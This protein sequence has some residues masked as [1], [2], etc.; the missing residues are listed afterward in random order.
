MKLSEKIASIGTDAF[1]GCSSLSSVVYAG[2]I[3]GWCGISGLG[4]IMTSD[5]ELS[6]GGNTL[7]GK[8]V[9]PEG[10]GKISDYAFYGCGGI[11]SVVL[12][13]DIQEIGRYAFGA[14]NA[15]SAIE[16]AGDVSAWCGIE[17]LGNIMSSGR[18]LFIGGEEPAGELVIGGVGK[19][20]DHAFYGCKALTSVI[21]SDGVTSV[22]SNA[23]YGCKA[24]TSVILSDD[25]TFIGSNAFGDCG[26]LA[27]VYYKGTQ[28]SW[29]RISIGFA[30]GDLTE[31]AR[32]Y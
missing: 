32:Y 17:G 19:I 1:F 24:L 31:V 25:V 18:T 16:Y 26:G 15:L 13:E 28:E 3:A 29:D 21:L 4:N 11:T 30:N 6:V 7:S 14:C 2:D 8:L 22:G 12:P 10:T 27:A 20:A 23:F 5:R 9:I